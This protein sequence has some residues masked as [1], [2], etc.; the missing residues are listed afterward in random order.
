LL[1]ARWAPPGRRGRAVAP[2]FRFLDGVLDTDTLARELQPLLAG[3]GVELYGIE[4]SAGAARLCVYIETPGREVTL[5]DCETASRVLSAWLDQADPVPGHYQL[6]VSSPGIER[7]LFT[8]AHYAAQ[9]G[10]E[11]SLLLKLPLAGGRRRLRGR[12]LHSDAQAIML[13]AEGGEY[14]LQ[15]AQ[16]QSARVV[17]DWVALG[18]APQ[19]R[20]GRTPRRP[21]GPAQ[22]G[23]AARSSKT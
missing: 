1:A 17:P 22:R 11:I 21:G 4:W 14:S 19:P 10:Q 16:I 3:T 7:P 18:H 5:D 2:F 9:Q 8:A 13:A 15:I 12:L 20:P 6:E 23:Q